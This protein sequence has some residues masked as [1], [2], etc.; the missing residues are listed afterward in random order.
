MNH[1][2][3]PP[4]FDTLT[5]H[6]R[7]LRT[8]Y[9]ILSLTNYSL[10]CWYYSVVYKKSCSQL[11]IFVSFSTQLFKKFLDFMELGSLL[12]CSQESLLSQMKPIQTFT[13]YL[14]KINLSAHWQN[15]EKWLLASPNL[16]VCPSIHLSVH[17]TVSLDQ[18]SSHPTNF[19][20]ILYMSTFQKSVK[21]L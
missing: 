11:K 16:S 18:L 21:K 12:R 2:F 9:D 1:H 14:S 8:I 4:T 13:L 7:P 6:Q 19:H 17:L 3:S 20:Q 15:C 10:N 5:L